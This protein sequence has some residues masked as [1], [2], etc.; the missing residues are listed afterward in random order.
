MIKNIF[1]VRKYVIAASISDAIKKEKNTPVSDVW[2]DE[3][4][5]NILVDAV[6]KNDKKTGF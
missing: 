1:V 2:L 3:T 5:K 4:C 6:Y